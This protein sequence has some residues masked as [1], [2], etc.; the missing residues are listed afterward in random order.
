[1]GFKVGPLVG[2]CVVCNIVGA[3]EIEGLDVG[4]TE[5]LTVGP[6][7]DGAAEGAATGLNIAGGKLTGFE[8]D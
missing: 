3:G 8:N 6:S 4:L 5:G 7:L 2:V 1:M